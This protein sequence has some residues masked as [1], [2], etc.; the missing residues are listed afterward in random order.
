VTVTFAVAAG[1]PVIAGHL[2][3]ITGPRRGLMLAAMVMAGLPY[4]NITAGA[5]SAQLRD[6]G[7]LSVHVRTGA[8]VRRGAH[9]ADITAAAR[10]TTPAGDV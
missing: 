2:V 8:L 7:G 5:I 10:R 6:L 1:L 3:D 4:V 9:A